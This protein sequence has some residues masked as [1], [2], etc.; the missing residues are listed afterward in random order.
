M[1]NANSYVIPE[2][3]RITALKI[4]NKEKHGKVSDTLKQIG[5]FG[6]AIFDEFTSLGIIIC[7]STAT[8]QTWKISELGR[9]YY[10]D[11]K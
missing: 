3:Q 2:K 7:G 9:M 5:D 8:A 6:Q 1:T 10:R 11:I 4:F